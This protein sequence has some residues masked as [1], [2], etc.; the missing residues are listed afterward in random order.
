VP[1]AS[2][3]MGRRMAREEG[4][5]MNVGELKAALNRYPDG[6]PAFRDGCE[7]YGP[8][9][10]KSVYIN[11]YDQLVLSDGEAPS[12]AELE[13]AKARVAEMQR[14]HEEWEAD[15]IAREIAFQEKWGHLLP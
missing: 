14:Q 9:E 6:A 15:Q 11:E 5:E 4:E 8:E 1:P 2:P 12:D 13:A 7:E 3:G 10:I